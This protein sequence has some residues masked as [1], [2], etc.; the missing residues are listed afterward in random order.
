MYL[1]DE[2]QFYWHISC[3]NVFAGHVHIAYIFLQN[4][5]VIYYPDN[6]VNP[7][8]KEPSEWIR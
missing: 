7:V 8:K 5:F 4:V 6:P 2:R 3:L 1:F